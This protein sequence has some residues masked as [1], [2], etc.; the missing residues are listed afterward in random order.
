M[1][2]ALNKGVKD[3]KINKP[4]LINSLRFASRENSP[5]RVEK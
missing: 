2:S 3:L 5:E 1:I 4:D